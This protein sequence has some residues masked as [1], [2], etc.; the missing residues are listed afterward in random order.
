MVCPESDEEKRKNILFVV[1]C[2]YSSICANNI[3]CGPIESI[4]DPYGNIVDEI[5]PEDE[6]Q[7]KMLE[8]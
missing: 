3:G 8:K 5:L 7:K 6:I 1:L 4:T 2:A